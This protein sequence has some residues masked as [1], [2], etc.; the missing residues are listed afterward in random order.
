MTM[1]CAGLSSAVP[2]SSTFSVLVFLI[3]VSLAGISETVSK[4]G[5]SEGS[6]LVWSIQ[7]KFPGWS[8]RDEIPVLVYLRG[9]SWDGLF[10][11]SFLG[12]FI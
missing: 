1:F 5:L 8:I 7:E 2:R 4:A 12:W 10:E 6:F 3:S 9:V 11:D